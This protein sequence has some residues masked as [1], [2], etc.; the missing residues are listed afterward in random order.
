MIK[1]GPFFKVFTH[2]YWGRHVWGNDETGKEPTREPTRYTTVQVAKQDGIL[3][4]GGRGV[5]EA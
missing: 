4:D 2:I 1:N 3:S 5:V